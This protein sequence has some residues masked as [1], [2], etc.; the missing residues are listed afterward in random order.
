MANCG[1][2]TLMCVIAKLFEPTSIVHIRVT[3][4]YQL[5]ALKGLLV[6]VY[7]CMYNMTSEKVIM[8]KECR[9]CGFNICSK[10]DVD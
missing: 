4:E 3:E 8:C 6:R 1:P 10:T 7:M 5:S 9:Y 2:I